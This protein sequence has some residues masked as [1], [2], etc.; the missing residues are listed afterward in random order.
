MTKAQRKSFEEEANTFVRQMETRYADLVAEY[1][2]A[3]W[4]LY[5][6]GSEEAAAEKERLSLATQRVFAA[7]EDWEQ[8]R[9]L[10]E[11][12][13]EITDP[14]LRREVEV[15][16]AKFL[17]ERPD[18]AIAEE[19]ARLEGQVVAQYNHHRGTY[20]GQKLSDNELKTLLET[21]QSSEE[22]REAYLA[23]KE[24]GAQVATTVLRLAELRNQA[25]RQLGY[26]DHYARALAA[27]ELDE[28]ELFGVLEALE[29][30]TEMPYRQ[31]KLELDMQLVSRF[32][33]ADARELRPWHYADPFF[34]RPPEGSHSP[35]EGLF[36]DGKEI[37]ELTVKTYDGMGLEIRDVLA[38]S[39]LYEREG[40]S[41]HAFC[42]HI[43]RRSDDVRVLCNLQ[44]NARWMETNLHEFGHAVY[45]K[46]IDQ[47]L[48]YW[49]RT[50]A[51]ISTTEAIAMLMGRLPNN[52]QW[53]GEIK[54]LSA[55]EVGGRVQAL[56][57]AQRF[58]LLVFM[59]WGLV[60]VY[61]ERDLYANPARPDL[62]ALW[63]DYVGRFQLL[64]RPDERDAPDWAAKIHL[65]TAPAYYQNYLLGELTASQ[66]QAYVEREVPGQSLVQNPAAGQYLLK[67][68]RLG[69]RYNWNDAVR[70]VTGEFLTPA[71]FV[72]QATV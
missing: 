58:A 43:D 65:A 63:W 1:E 21:S 35:L 62:N 59:R 16:Y 20:H 71:Y 40:K 33:L 3:W 41:Q 27:Q 32:G 34:Q 15:L 4:N 11:K 68:F 31:A 61:F 60:M 69:A 66:L 26:R 53:L 28:A 49:L 45:D 70:E 30:A 9:N 42:T 38:R 56:T 25:A 46:Y 36:R 2:L 44:P 48:P 24:V 14:L 39:D 17:E 6:T 67:L 5:T 18:P 51:H 19:I 29:A 13:A 37:E 64:A 22:V 23:G 50:I 10:Y 57:Q 47:T 12:R 7:Q 54:G 52:R 72:Q 55:A 8:S